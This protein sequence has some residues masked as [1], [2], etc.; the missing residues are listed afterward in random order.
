M[1]HDRS[2]TRQPRA[3]FPLVFML[4]VL[5]L[6]VLRQ[7]GMLAAPPNFSPLMAL[8]FAGAI[9]FPKPLPWWSWAV[10]LL[11]I[12]LVSE[13]TSWWSHAEGRPEVLTAYACYAAAALWGGRLRER[14]GMI[15]TLAGTVACSTAF[16]VVTNSVSWWLS[17]GYAKTVSG[18]VQ[19]LTVGLPNVHPT[20]LE[21]FRNSLAA[22]LLGSIV[23]LAIYNAEA[24]CR[25]FAAIP[26]LAPRAA[27]ARS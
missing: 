3:W 14:T 13:N 21:F 22:D 17:A 7:H 6:R 24:V 8:A 16:Y 23:L 5:V 11:G 12:D 2:S 10:M 20:T 15:G 1:F 18:W 26:L 4:I 19:A 25:S 27:V 9:V